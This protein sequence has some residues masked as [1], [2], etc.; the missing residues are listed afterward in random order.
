MSQSNGGSG[1]AGCSIPA[2]ASI[3]GG[4]GSVADSS[5]ITGVPK[6]GPIAEIF[7]FQECGSMTG[8][9]VHTGS[10][11]KFTEG[12]DS[13][14]SK[15]KAGQGKAAGKVKKSAAKAVAKKSAGKSAKK[16]SAKKG[17]AKKGSAKKGA[18]GK[19]T[20]KK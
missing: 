5:E 14:F 17:S 9:T 20:G 15:G 13:I 1:G 4:S 10:N 12:W 6:G 8:Y 16:G 2:V 11:E 7:R 19:K 3:N 18:A